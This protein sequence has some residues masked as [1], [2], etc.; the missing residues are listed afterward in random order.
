MT[1]PGTTPQLASTSG[2]STTPTLGIV[3]GGQLALYLCRAA[4]RLDIRTLVLTDGPDTPAVHAAD[5]VLVAG[6]DDQVAVGELIELSDVITFELED[7]PRSTLDA[8][9]R[10]AAAGQAE[11]NPS[12][13]TL[14]LIQ[15]KATQKR[16]LADQDLA[17]ADFKALTGNPAEDAKA[18]ERFGLPA[19]QKAERGG[20]DGHGVQI[21]RDASALE[22]VWPTASF[23]ERFVSHSDELA[24]VVVRGGDGSLHAYPPVKMSFDD[25]DNILTAVIAPAA[26]EPV[27]AERAVALAT[28][29]I[30]ALA[31]VGVFAVELFVDPDGEVLINEISPRVHNAGHLSMEAA[32]TCQFEMHVRAVTGMALPEAR[33]HSAA[34][35]LN[36]L[37]D[38]DLAQ[39]T[40]SD[41][42]DISAGAA[43]VHWYGKKSA[44]PK[45]KMGHLTATAATA[46]DASERANYARRAF[47]ALA[48]GHA[49]GLSEGKEE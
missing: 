13:A 14:A 46:A 21:L 5:R 44:K 28:R 11:V 47:A 43:H 36:L 2:A 39:L 24:V 1:P 17:T 30:G 27:V 38:D 16:W 22:R 48:R 23:V 19:V 8:L 31:D 18:I 29:A 15:N 34:V 42:I 10:A 20:Y 9:S 40:A 25:D 26:I 32:D 45:R 37:C 7:V 12:P 33:F 3:G 35:M 6:L 41:V 4:R 49:Q